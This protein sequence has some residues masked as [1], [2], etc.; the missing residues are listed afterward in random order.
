MPLFI[1]KIPYCILL[2]NIGGKDPLNVSAQSGINLILLLL[3]LVRPLQ[4]YYIIAPG[5]IYQSPDAASVISH[6]LVNI[7]LIENDD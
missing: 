2:E 3:F 5:H 4:E 6:R 7:R 1:D